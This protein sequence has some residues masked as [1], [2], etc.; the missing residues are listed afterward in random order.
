[1]IDAVSGE[2]NVSVSYDLAM[3]KKAMDTTVEIAGQEMSRML[4]ELA[5]ATP[6][7]GDFIDT[8]A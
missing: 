4:E 1:M 5:V 2:I 3:A 6:A 8:Y 7:K